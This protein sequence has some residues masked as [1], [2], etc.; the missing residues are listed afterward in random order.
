ME[1]HMNLRFL[2][3]LSLALVAVAGLL[4]LIASAQA[5]PSR[6]IRFIVPFPAGSA[7]DSIARVMSQHMQQTLGQPIVIDN[8]PGVQGA[9][10]AAEAARAAPDGYTIFGGNN[11]TLAANPSLY[12]KLQY[13]PAKDF[14]PVGL[15]I[16]A[17]LTLVV[18]PD[19]PAKNMHEFIAYAKANPGKLSAGYA[20]A[21]MQVSMGELKTLGGVDFL[22]V[23]YKGVPQA[24]S[25]LIG[26]QIAFTF[27]DNAVAFTQIR[28]GKLRGLGVTS[29]KRTSLMPEMP[30][31]SEELPGFDVK[32]W[33][34]LVVPTG[35]P[36]E[37]ID[38]LWDASRKALAAPEVVK[39]LN[40]LGL[41]VTPMGPEEFGPFITAE[42]A[43][44]ARQIKAAGIQPE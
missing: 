27:A 2:K 13:N 10:A 30:A 41:D 16:T 40:T 6:P 15:Y 18:R 20:S 26:G 14:V 17:S 1:T 5:Y 44:W 25:D 7:P 33:S 9:I 29:P 23:P 21:G 3:L 28:A 36:K 4:P 22:E 34:G 19:F 42:A 32:V 43:K 39:S 12:K 31:L 37:V 35:T 38:K 8:K 11:S 24:V